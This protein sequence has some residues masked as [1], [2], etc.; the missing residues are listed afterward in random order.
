[1]A[2]VFL[3]VG[4]HKTATSYLQGSFYA[5]RKLLKSAGLCYPHIGPNNAHH[6]LAGQWIKINDLPENF[7]GPRGPEGIWNDLIEKY[8]DQPGTLFLSAENFT[9][10]FPEK[11]DWA[12]LAARLSAFDEIKI[13]Y[14]MRR[15]VELVPSVWSQITKVNYQPSIWSFMHTVIDERRAKG[16]P[17]DHN[18]V[19]EELR[20][21]FAPE[22]IHLLDYS[23]FRHHPG[24][25][26]GVFLDLMGVDLPIER[27]APPSETEANISPDALAL[28]VAGVVCDDNSQPPDPALTRYIETQLDE[29]VGPT[30]TLL[31]RHEYARVSHR[32]QHGNQSLVEKVQRYQPGFT[33]D[34]GAPAR[35]TGVSR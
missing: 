30:R 17:V 2:R 32:F 13:V 35:R 19:Y 25:V 12:D 7:Y 27:M 29:I 23:D 4:A 20:Q 22:Q 16:V 18:M 1:M 24:G 6:A 26:V 15:Q 34:E 8:A 28:F 33:F 21:S 14:T 3:H 31:A 9:R 5:N 10:C 11:V